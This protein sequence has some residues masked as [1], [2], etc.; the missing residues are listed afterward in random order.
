M[1]IIIPATFP[2]Q[3]RMENLYRNSICL[4]TPPSNF[5]VDERVFVNLG[6]LKV[7]AVLEQ[8][9][10]DVEVLDFSGIHDYAPSLHNQ[11]MS[12]GC[13]TFGITGT[14]PQMPDVINI[15]RQIRAVLPG[16]RIILGGPHIT[17]ALSSAKKELSRGIIGRATKA[18]NSLKTCFDVLVSGDG[19]KA[20]FEA[21]R[22]DAPQL[23]DANDHHS[24]L[25]LSSNDFN[26]LPFPARHL[27]DLPSYRYSI[28]GAP[29]TSIIGQLGCP[30]TCA[31]CGGRD[32]PSHRMVRIRT[33]DSIIDEIRMLYETC[34]FTGF[35]FYDD[36][37]NVN[38]HF[39]ELLDRLITLQV[40]LG[41]RFHFR[42]FVR[43]ELFNER[44]AKAMLQAG[45]RWILSG[46]ESGSPRMLENM[47]ARAGR[48]EN[49][50][51]IET[52]HKH[53]LMVK[54]LMSIGHP[55]E[56]HKTIDETRDWL[57]KAAPDDFDI[58]LITPY[59]GSAYY[60]RSAPVLE[61]PDM[62]VYTAPLTGDKLYCPEID[63]TQTS[64]YYNGNPYRRNPVFTATDHLTS[65]DLLKL[66]NELEHDLRAAL[67]T[68]YNASGD[69][70]HYFDHSMGQTGGLPEHILK[71]RHVSLVA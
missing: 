15:A 52:A 58:T 70:L 33:V 50:R 27:I 64:V 66:R 71:T 62:W 17:L 6:I 54:A 7:A 67:G 20:I 13:R 26:A 39:T 43:A 56:S 49:L 30:F 10:Y 12:S 21:L 35:K 68:P 59:P 38:P 42:G 23:I 25:F 9:G 24:L 37:L 69:T 31:F 53:G 36:E 2:E 22:E 29:A 8:S 14:T 32:S 44:Q 55:G 4:I 1:C 48:E 18:F 65:K 63:Y 40:Q 61:N 41:V 57:Q 45:F 28:D 11:L 16:A 34:G 46:I 60:D 51:F 3:G 47:N 5:L 19:E